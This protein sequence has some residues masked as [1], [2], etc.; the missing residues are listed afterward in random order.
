MVCSNSAVCPPV[1][2]ANGVF[3]FQHNT[4]SRPV[5]GTTVSIRCN[6]GKVPREGVTFAT[7]S[8]DGNWFPST[9]GCGDG[10][11]VLSLSSHVLADSSNNYPGTHLTFSCVQPYTLQGPVGITCLESGQWSAQPPTCI[12]FHCPP[13][14]LTANMITSGNGNQVGDTVVFGCTNSFQLVGVSSIVCGVDGS[15]SS[16]P[17]VC[18]HSGGD[19]TTCFLQSLP[20]HLVASAQFANLGDTITFSCAEG[21]LLDGLGGVTCGTNRTWSSQIPS[22]IKAASSS[23]S[24]KSSSVALGILVGILVLALTIVVTAI[25][26]WQVARYMNKKKAYQE[27][28]VRAHV[29][30]A[31][32]AGGRVNFFATNGDF[33]EDGDG[34][35]PVYRDR[36]DEQL[37]NL[38]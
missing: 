5:Q 9:P 12:P 10:C 8:P 13:V 7:C 37:L 15:W 31:G 24:S 19:S 22:C 2:T 16:P 34:D 3:S 4:T 25:V 1:N 14:N 27:L 33:D 23:A 30:G 28:S 6:S 17:P 35:E 21:Y 18:S 26:V 11:P 38:K 32:D 36:D 20:T 29:D